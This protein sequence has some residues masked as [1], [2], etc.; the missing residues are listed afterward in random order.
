[1]VIRLTL[2]QTITPDHLRGRVSA[3]N[4]VFIGFSNEFGAFESGATAALFGPTLSVVGGG[5]ATFIVVGVVAATWPQLARIGPLHSLAPAETRSDLTPAPAPAR[6]SHRA[7]AHRLRHNVGTMK[8]LLVLRHAKSSWD[9]AGLDD[10][11]RPLNERGERDAP[12]MGELV[13]EQQLM[14]DLIISSDATRARLTAEAM[15]DAAGYEGTILLERRLYH[16]SPT[17]IV[18]LLHSVVDAELETVMIVGHNPGLEELVT[19][20]TGSPEDVPTAALAQ[21]ELPIERWA[22]LTASTR[23]RLVEMWRPRDLD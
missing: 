16:A 7:G 4:Y 15:A 5:I 13:R 17:E 2:E 19:A 8:T 23:G 21:I 11:E 1:M 20:L 3:I 9:D 10:H 14:P 12:R 18:D 6:A 22:N